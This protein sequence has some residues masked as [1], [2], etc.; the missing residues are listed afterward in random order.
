[1]SK[2]QKKNLNYQTKAVNNTI[3]YLK[4]VD[5]FS[6]QAPT[7]SGK[8]YIIASIIDKYLETADFMSEAT[9]FLFI[10]PSTG[11]L[12]HQ[13]YEK[14]SNY[15]KNDWVKGFQTN[16][17]GSTNKNSKSEYLKNIE[18]FKPNNVYFIGWNLL[19][20]NTK[21]MNIDSERNDLF[22]VIANTKD[23]NI[24]I[25]LIIDEAH[26]EFDSELSANSRK[27]VLKNLDAFKTICV[28][29]TLDN[30]DFTISSQEVRDEAAIKEKVIIN[31]GLSDIH[32]Y[33]EY[34]NSDQVTILI[35]TAIAKQEEIKKEYFK[36]N[37]SNKPLLLIQI[38]N[39]ITDEEYKRSY[40][41]QIEKIIENKGY[42]KNE[43]YAVWLDKEKPKMSKSDI[44]KLD[45]SIEILIF[46][47]AIA[48]GWDIPR[49]NILVRL[50]EAKSSQFNIQT[51][52]RILRNPFF[53]FYK[54]PLI[55]NAFVYTFDKKYEDLIR[56]ENFVYDESNIKKIGRSPK[57][58]NFSMHLNKVLINFDNSEEKI[59]NLINHVVNKLFTNNN[60]ISDFFKIDTLNT[61][62]DDISIESKEIISNSTKVKDELNEKHIQQKFSISPKDTLVNLYI[63]YK[64]I[65]NKSNLYEQIFNNLIYSEKFK[66]LN[67]TIKDF[68]LSMTSNWNRGIFTKE[69]S[70]YKS[71]IFEF[72]E[73]L[74]NKYQ[75]EKFEFNKEE[76][77]LPKNYFF[78]D[79]F[80]NLCKWDAINVFDVTLIE[81]KLSI[82]ERE[83]YHDFKNKFSDNENIFIFRN[84][85]GNQDYYLEYFNNESKKS[86]FY[87][88]FILVNKKNKK[89][90]IFEVKG[91]KKNNIDNETENKFKSI[92]SW[93]EHIVNSFDKYDVEFYFVSFNNNELIFIDKDK[94]EFTFEH[95][96]T[97]IKNYSRS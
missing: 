95:I 68:Y 32:K 5:M 80:F 48:I 56:Q 39:D 15:L 34:E 69:N 91:F 93:S 41:N 29:A 44:T 75:K 46:K 74:I 33:D 55:D 18:Y 86:K 16:Y 62:D 89:I 92:N 19:S 47:Q 42:K 27:D 9:T 28:S 90:K 45:S 25:V 72:I 66:K 10:A 58:I 26:R 84:Q 87:P 14:I 57:G 13:G 88:D 94:N 30:P 83:F 24:K 8:T 23:E 54:S 82:N 73:S 85:V 36:K 40:C 4:T 31:A 70:I 43:N 38:P 67:K 49:A 53:K 1:M 77:I 78:N 17:I 7:G 37:I 35:N 52:G 51:L 21:I 71:T 63:K 59:N 79:Q 20:K 61:M 11:K 50:R 22:K 64:T 3:E 76:Y 65:I 97:V 81:N 2:N 12:D 96:T 6:L 60:F